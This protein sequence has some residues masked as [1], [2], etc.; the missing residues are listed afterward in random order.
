MF[1]QATTQTLGQAARLLAILVSAGALSA[2]TLSQGLEMAAPV[3]TDPSEQARI[4]QPAPTATATETE[5]ADILPVNT[6][7]LSAGCAPNTSWPIYTIAPGDTLSSIAQRVNSTVAALAQ[8]NCLANPN[9]IAVGQRIR[10]PSLPA[11]TAPPPALPLISYPGQPASDQCAVFVNSA[12]AVYIYASPNSSDT[13]L[14]ILGN[15]APWQQTI[16]GG[17]A[18]ALPDK[19]TGWVQ[20]QYTTLVGN[21]EHARF[22]GPIPTEAVALPIVGFD[23]AIPETGCFVV[24]DASQVYVYGPGDGPGPIA[25]LYEFARHTGSTDN[26]YEIELPGFGY[27][28]WVYK[29]DTY[30]AG[31]DCPS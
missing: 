28:G 22:P 31:S 27:D 2:C 19:T 26:A 12:D 25:M 16:V 29:A 20:D 1:Y 3:I 4:E 8:A 7:A 15:Y 23:G 6:A 14:G 24:R 30:L 11:A 21:C 9:T 10:V 18:I 5:Q 13:V 17:Y